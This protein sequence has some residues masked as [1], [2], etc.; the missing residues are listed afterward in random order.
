MS[1]AF[2]EPP[3]QTPEQLATDLCQRYSHP[4][5]NGPCPRVIPCSVDCAC[6]GRIP[7]DCACRGHGPAVPVLEA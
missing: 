4:S 7:W 5:H 6:G 2:P 3:V 1:P